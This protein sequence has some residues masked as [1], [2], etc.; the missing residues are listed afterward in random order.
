[1]IKKF[2]ILVSAF[3]LS[4][5]SLYPSGTQ[6]SAVPPTSTQPVISPE[7]SGTLSPSTEPLSSTTVSI[8]ESGFEPASVTINA[9]ETIIWNN[10][11]TA[12]HTVN[13]DPHPIHTTY[14]PLNLGP[15][16]PGTSKSLSFPTPGTYTYHDH[17]NPSLK[18]TVIVQ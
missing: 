7:V 8:S 13:S 4:A 10:A 9:G 5:C 2:V 18:G 6:D 16:S 1:M 11:D 3:L 14:P 15:I 17:L 12:T